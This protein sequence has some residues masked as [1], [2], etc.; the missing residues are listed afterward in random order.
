MFHWFAFGLGASPLEHT[1]GEAAK[2]LFFLQNL[3]EEQRHVNK[4]T[5]WGTDSERIAALY[6]PFEV[7]AKG[8]ATPISSS[9]SSTTPPRYE[10]NADIPAEFIEA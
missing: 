2:Y 3:F 9:S 7:T 5:S 1:Q 10:D 8:T 4:T 6:G